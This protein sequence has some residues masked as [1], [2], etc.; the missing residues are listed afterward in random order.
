MYV[1]F[2]LI[3]LLFVMGNDHII[4]LSSNGSQNLFRDNVPGNFINKLSTPILLDNNIEYEV[5]LVSIL[6]PDQY[7]AVLANDENYD[8]T[9]YTR[10]KG[11]RRSS[12]TVRMKENILAGNM[13]KIIKIVNRNLLEYMERHYHTFF[14]HLFPKEE[15]RRI[16]HWNDTERRV[17][18]LCRK[19]NSHDRIIADIK[20]ID[21]KMSRGLSSLMGYN[22]NTQY[23]V[24]SQNNLMKFI[25]VLVLLHLSAE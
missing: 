15:D 23:T 18:I 21:I 5:G 14:P 9:L 17:E 8:I 1:Y 3:H 13:P 2:F 11:L 20:R 25:K 12:L 6:Y 10:Q 22:S 24:Y 4:Y 19:G 7:Y 16:F